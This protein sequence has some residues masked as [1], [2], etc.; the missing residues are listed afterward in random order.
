MV[1]SKNMRTDTDKRLDDYLLDTITLK[2]AAISGGTI[3]LEW[4]ADG[5]LLKNAYTFPFVFADNPAVAQE[6]TRDTFAA[7]FGAIR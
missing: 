2:A 3:H 7:I 1:L 5:H 4:D 6:R